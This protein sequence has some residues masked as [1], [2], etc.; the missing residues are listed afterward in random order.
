MFAFSHQ[1]ACGSFSNLLKIHITTS[2]K[3]NE[4]DSSKKEAGGDDEEIKV[5]QKGTKQNIMN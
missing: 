3:E 5:S 4:N 2:K 1:T